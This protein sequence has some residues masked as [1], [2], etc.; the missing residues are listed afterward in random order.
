MELLFVFETSL[1]KYYLTSER[2]IDDAID[3]KTFML[4]K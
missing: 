4:T 1:L 3:N 2:N